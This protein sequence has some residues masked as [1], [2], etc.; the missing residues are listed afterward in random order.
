MSVVVHIDDGSLEMPL[1]SLSGTT[2]E[3]NGDRLAGTAGLVV[4]VAK[5]LASLELSR[6]GGGNAS[7]GGGNSEELHVDDEKDG[8]CEGI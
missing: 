3:E 6:G 7:E 2:S 4:G 5:K 1:T 8:D